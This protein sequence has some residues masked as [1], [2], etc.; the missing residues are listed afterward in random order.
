MASIQRI[1]LFVFFDSV[2]AD[3]V[4]RIRSIPNEDGSSLLSEDERDKAKLRL[5]KISNIPES[6]D[7]GAL[8][9][10]LDIGDKYSV[11]MRN[12]P[13]LPK[14]TRDYYKSL[15][16]SFEKVIPVRNAVMHGRPL[17]VSQHTQA[18]AFASDLVKA[19]GYW[20]TLAKSFQ[21]YDKDP[22]G[23][24]KAAKISF[25]EG[26]TPGVFHNLPSPDYDDTGFI[27]RDALQA[28]LRKK[29][30]G[31]HPVITVLGDGGDGKTSI[32]LQCLHDLIASN[33]HPF[34]GI[35]WV[36]AKSNRLGIKEVERIEGSILDSM[37]LFRS[38]SNTFG[39]DAT[40]PLERVWQLLDSN[41][42][43][44]VIDNLETVLDDSIKKFAENVPGESKVLFTS[45]VPLGSDLTVKVGPFSTSESIKLLRALASSYNI[46]SLQKWGN[47]KLASYSSRLFNKPLLLKWFALGVSSGLSP[48]RI[49]ANPD[50]ALSFCLENVIGSLSS[51]ARRLA[52]VLAVVPG[53]IS[54]AVLSHVVD[55]SAKLVESTVAELLRFGL[56]EQTDDRI[57]QTYRLRNFARSYISRQTNLKP[58]DAANI[59]SSLR[60]VDSTYN[61]EMIS[62]QHDRYNM[63]TYVVASKSD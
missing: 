2:E 33:D 62:A 17:T 7:D 21:D 37:D 14:A 41:K 11:L 6:A 12:A 36:S 30:L 19:A 63:K 46:N 60:S 10:G 20:P 42:I 58:K 29:I 31:R 45:R 32:S 34:D 56:L 25:I 27:P 51:D 54:V 50:K 47:D 13:R 4:S 48:D 53:P 28:D 39:E 49:V 8:L 15:K 1:A 23:I 52:G 38:V 55:F 3:L 44:L 5:E 43:L 9:H 61:H 35:V 59:I 26:E 16:N 24:I 40:D 57:D 18:F 22:E